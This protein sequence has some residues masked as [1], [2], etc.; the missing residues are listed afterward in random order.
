MIYNAHCPECG[1]KYELDD[2]MDM[3]P[4][5]PTR[6]WPA[7]WSVS[8]GEGGAL[9]DC[10]DCGEDFDDETVA[11]MAATA[12]LEPDYPWADKPAGASQAS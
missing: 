5:I 7:R 1:R 12:G 8:N 11:A 10:Y 3:W 2:T 4:P 6:H 9:G